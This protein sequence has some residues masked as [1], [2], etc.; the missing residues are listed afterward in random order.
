MHRAAAITGNHN[1]MD[2]TVAPTG[3][4][5]LMDL[6]ASIDV[7][8]SGKIDLQEFGQSDKIRATGPWNEERKTKQF[9]NTDTNSDNVIDVGE[10]LKFAS[11][12]NVVKEPISAVGGAL[13]KSPS[14]TLTNFRRMVV[15]MPGDAAP[16]YN[17]GVL[18]C[19]LGRSAE[20]KKP[21]AEVTHRS[22]CRV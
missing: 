4:D 12:V 7:D 17:L 15:D 3:Q 14:T 11:R 13:G 8:K 2:T 18:L 20:A 19:D 16:L 5:Q 6:F 22:F 21:F 10:F 1:H 9:R